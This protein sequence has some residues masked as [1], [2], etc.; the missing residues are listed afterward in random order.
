MI[1]WEQILAQAKKDREEY[2]KL[3]K[4]HRDFLERQVAEIRKP[5]YVPERD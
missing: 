5:A 4:W 3:P 1:T 2:D